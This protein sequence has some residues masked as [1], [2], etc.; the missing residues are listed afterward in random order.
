MSPRPLRLPWRRAASRPW[1]TGI[2]VCSFLCPEL[3]EE[4]D[5]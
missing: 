4:F 5:S 3:S 1:S 2:D